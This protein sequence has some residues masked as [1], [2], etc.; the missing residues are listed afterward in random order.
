ML[1]FLAAV[2]I[3]WSTYKE[4]IRSVTSSLPEVGPDVRSRLSDIARPKRT[5]VF[6]MLAAGAILFGTALLGAWYHFHR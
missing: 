3:L 6:M 2:W 5:I 1:I 4:G